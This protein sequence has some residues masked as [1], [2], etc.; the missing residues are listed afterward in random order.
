MPSFQLAE[1]KREY[2]KN[3]RIGLMFPFT[4]LSC[5]MVLAGLTVHAQGPSSTFRNDGRFTI[6]NSIDAGTFINTGELTYLSVPPASGFGN[7]GDVFET[8]N[9]LSYTN[10][11]TISANPGFFFQNVDYSGARRPASVI[12]NSQNGVI[13]ADGQPYLIPAPFYPENNPHTF[14]HGGYLVLSATNIINRGLLS[15]SFSG[16]LLLEGQSVDLKRSAMINQ[17]RQSA[18]FGLQSGYPVANPTFWTYSPPT[19]TR[20]LFWLANEEFAFAPRALTSPTNITTVFNTPQGPVT[21]VTTNAIANIGFFGS[22]ENPVPDPLNLTRG[23]SVRGLAESFIRTNQVN[24]TNQTID[25][26]FVVSN[27]RDVLISANLDEPTSF[28]GMSV[29]FGLLTTNN[30][31]SSVDLNRVRVIQDF[32]F[33]PTNIYHTDTRNPATMI[34]RNFFVDRLPR[35]NIPVSRADRQFIGQELEPRNVLS[36][37]NIL[38]THMGRGGAGDNAPYRADLFTTGYFTNFPPGKWDFAEQFIVTNIA[39]YSF[40]VTPLPSLLPAVPGVVFPTNSAGRIRINAENLELQDARIRSLGTTVIKARNLVSSRNTSVAAPSVWYELG[41]TNGTLVYE[42]MNPI[43]QPGLSGTVT[44]FTTSWIASAEFPDPNSTD[45]NSTSTV[46]INTT[47]RVFFVQGVFAATPPL[48]TI[49]YL[50]LNATNLV[51]NDPITYQI[52]DPISVPI[53]DGFG[54]SQMAQNVEQVAPITQN[55]INNDSISI[56]GTVG[57]SP[58][59]FP[60]LLTVSNSFT[61]SLFSA[62]SMTLGTSQRPL[63]IINNDGSLSSDGAI[64]LNAVAVTNRG[65]VDAT[66]PVTIAGSDVVFDGSLGGFDVESGPLLSLSGSRFQTILGGQVSSD[67]IIDLDFSE[68]FTTDPA[69]I[70]TFH[71]PVGIRL[72]RNATVN[73]LDGVNLSL[74]AGRFENAFLEWAGA[75]VGTEQAGFSNNSAV[76]SLTM[77]VDEFGFIELGAVGNTPAALY[78]RRLELGSG[79]TEFITNGVVDFEGLATILDILPGMRVY[80]N[81]VSVDGKELNPTLLDGAYDGRLRLINNPGADGGSLSFDLGGGFGVTTSWGVRYSTVLDSDGDGVPNAS[82]TTPFSGAVVSTKVTDINGR[83]YFEISWNA[84]ANTSYDIL[85]KDGTSSSSSWTRIGSLSNGTGTGNSLKFYDPMDTGSA[86][87]YRVVYR[88]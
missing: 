57:I 34:P 9:T 42:G 69:S 25:A 71:S 80:Y 4:V 75:D 72:A 61:G 81:T 7:F 23:G 78:V 83:S 33:F 73:N 35:I 38:F 24:P 63:S 79:F 47:F 18:E 19:G 82:D 22:I 74:L 6:I 59:S 53:I 87:T 26:I 44:A 58:R 43:N 70:V 56:S 84:A 11:G 2:M 76:A 21:V 8:L 37:S 14:A 51:V 16:D 86:K 15:I 28:G 62:F 31:N 77:D 54:G 27:N 29:D 13:S 66:G 60:S 49:S 36:R 64:N 85:S 50:K 48:G 55:W 20:G 5:C 88:P 68:R 40:L 39:T 65:S 30:A 45:T 67:G 3:L 1:I 41:A 10:I 46:T 12:Y 17:S 32:T 52:P